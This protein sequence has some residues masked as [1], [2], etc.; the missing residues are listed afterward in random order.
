MSGEGV[1][2]ETGVHEDGEGDYVW[3]LEGCCVRAV[4][5]LGVIGLNGQ[6]EE[7]TYACH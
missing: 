1:G 7:G 3:D 2:G 6:G 5:S 4:V